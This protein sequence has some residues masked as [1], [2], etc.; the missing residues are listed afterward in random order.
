[1]IRISGSKLQEGM[2]MKYI[3]DLKEGDTVNDIYL[4]KKKLSLTAK[5]GRAYDSLTLQD[6]T[7]SVDAKIW[8][9]GSVGIE[10]FSEMDYVDIMG[11]VTVYQKKLQLNVKRARKCHEGEYNP[12][13][14]VPVTKKNIREMYQELINL[15][16]T[17]K[18]PHLRQLIIKFFIEDEEFKKQFQRSS[19]AKTVH[20]GFL[21]GLLEH[22]LGVTKLCS[23]FADNYPFLNRDLLITAAIFHDIGK[24][25][26]LSSF[27]KN[28]YTDEGQLIGHII[29]GVEMIDEKIKEI[30][31]FP[32]TL[33][34]ELRHC[35]LAHHGELEFGSPKKPA[36][37]EAAAL[38][39]ADNADAKLEIF[40]EFLE[41][42][43]ESPWLGFQPLLDSNIRKTEI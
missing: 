17:V 4:V 20:H 24:T 40:R 18:E 38:N 39:F 33:S 3:K 29:I 27:P 6:K 43:S 34:N 28:D 25:K 30:P 41:T 12:E 26:E 32:E 1:M 5:N 7:G 16:N 13:E 9:P 23:T 15:A 35:I 19:A 22:T 42:K 10:D 14:Y 2:Y 11:E 37:A 31:D 36:I 8:E 21:G